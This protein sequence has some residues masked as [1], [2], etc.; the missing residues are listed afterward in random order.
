M[1]QAMIPQ[2]D[3]KAS[4][5]AQKTEI[6]AAVARV[7]GGG[8]YILGP[9]VEAFEA[10]FASWLGVGW[11]VG[12]ASGTDA[13]A[14]ALRV[15]GIGRGDAVATVSHTATAT[16]AAIELAGAR[17]VFVDIEASSFNMAPAALERLMASPPAPIRAVI[18][19]HLYG[20]PAR[21]GEIRDIARRHGA[22][23]IEDAAQAHG[24]AVDGRK[25]GALGELGAFSFYPTKNLG[26][27]GD[28][29]ALAGSD[30]ELERRARSLRQYGWAQR[31]VAASPG[32]NTRLHEV[33][34]A[35]LRVKLGRLDE[36]NAR[37]R[38]VAAAY[39]QGLQRCDL[40]LPGSGRGETCVWHQYVV[41][42]AA[43]ER[44]IRA[45][46]ERN[47][48][49]AV[50]YPVPVHR[51]P[52]YAGRIA[53]GPGGLPVTDQLSAEILSL[54]MFPEMSDEAVARVIEAVASTVG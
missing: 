27:F 16:V 47:V 21:I 15:M 46:A 19:V 44:I 38:A 41:R 49:A 35:V 20:R 3:P 33:Q 48:G 39:S 10:E 30:P 17:P 25:A 9:E 8:A 28:A 6:D 14:L 12:V 22:V 36:A 13:L 53:I 2:T 34:A 32:M 24:A 31:F 54:P 40:V 26:A 51:Q 23:V 1:T 52:A 50:H 43:R 7:L 18:P 4:Y 45:L 37:R 29:G 5:L 42:A 11:A